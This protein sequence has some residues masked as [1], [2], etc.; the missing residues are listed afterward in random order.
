MKDRGDY[1][2]FAVISVGKIRASSLDVTDSR[3]IFCGHADLQLGIKRPFGEDGEPEDE[4][5]TAKIRELG[6]MLV[7][8]SMTRLDTHVDQDSWHPDDP[9]LPKAKEEKPT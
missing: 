1:R 7:T 6:K 4:L 9:W 3:E 2:G 8:L 5:I